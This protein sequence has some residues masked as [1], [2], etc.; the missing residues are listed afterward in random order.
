MT[1]KAFKEKYFLIVLLLNQYGN[2]I[3]ENDRS[4]RLYTENKFSIASESPI[5]FR[6]EMSCSD[7][8]CGKSFV[9]RTPVF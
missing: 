5:S 4:V 2:C 7:P 8:L 6:Y 9:N 3:M 1:L